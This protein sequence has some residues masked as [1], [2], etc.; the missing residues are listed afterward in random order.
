MQTCLLVNTRSTGFQ[1]QIQFQKNFIA[2]RNNATSESIIKEANYKCV[3]KTAFTLRLRLPNRIYTYTH[4]HIYRIT[5]RICMVGCDLFCYCYNLV[6]T[7][8]PPKTGQ[9]AWLHP[10][11]EINQYQTTTECNK[12]RTAHSMC[13]E[14]TTK[15]IMDD[16]LRIYAHPFSYYCYLHILFP[17]IYQY[18][19]RT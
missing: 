13:C 5:L 15:L 8:Y 7:S 18:V 10:G 2:T 16:V 12:T 1:I 14:C 3:H 9:I 6:I 19:L 11:C 17:Q 4:T